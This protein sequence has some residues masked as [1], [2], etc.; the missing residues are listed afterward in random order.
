MLFVVLINIPF[1]YWR[2]S[3]RKYSLQWFTAIHLPVIL[4]ITIRLS[5]G[6]ELNIYLVLLTVV[7]LFS[8]QLIGQRIFIK[9]KKS[10]SQPLTSC[11]VMDLVRARS[12]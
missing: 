1:G 4:I 11:L 5:A 6:L 3:V 7:F 12:N 8:G 10:R 2:E 9:R